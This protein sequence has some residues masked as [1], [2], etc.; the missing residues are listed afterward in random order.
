MTG[1][2]CPNCKNKELILYGYQSTRPVLICPNCEKL[3]YYKEKCCI[4]DCNNMVFIREDGYDDCN[5]GVW[6]KDR[7]FTLFICRDCKKPFLLL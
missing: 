1:Y 7:R 2:Y 5:Q 6:L 4:K 3:Y